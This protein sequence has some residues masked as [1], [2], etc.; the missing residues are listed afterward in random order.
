LGANLKKGGA[1]KTFLVVYVQ[2]EIKFKENQD[3]GEE[4]K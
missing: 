1:G 3:R 2:K 4:A